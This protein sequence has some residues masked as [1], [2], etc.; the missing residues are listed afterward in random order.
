MTAGKPSQPANSERLRDLMR[1]AMIR[2]TR[3][4]VALK[5]SRRHASTR[6]VDPTPREQAAYRELVE[7]IRALVA[8]DRHSRHRLVAHHLLSA[9]GSSPDA[10]CAAIARFAARHDSHPA[11]QALADRWAARQPSGIAYLDD[12]ARSAP[13]R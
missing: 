3:A 2:N 8:G 7:Q 11:W 13:S 4:V 10:A 9:A 5:F 12:R 6:S 1:D